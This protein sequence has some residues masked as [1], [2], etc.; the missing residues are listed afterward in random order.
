MAERVTVTINGVRVEVPAHVTVLAALIM[1]GIVTFRKSVRG[2]MRGP[3][4]GIG[5][6]FECR[7]TINGQHHSRSCQVLCQ[8]GMD[9]R[10]E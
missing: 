9:V 5:V 7:V 3:L 8:E 1:H 2:E 4:C 10:T 6:C